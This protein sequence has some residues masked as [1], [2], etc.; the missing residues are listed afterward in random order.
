MKIIKIKIKTKPLT[1]GCAGGCGGGGCG[2]TT[3]IGLKIKK[4]KK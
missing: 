1:T 2:S 3:C 4:I